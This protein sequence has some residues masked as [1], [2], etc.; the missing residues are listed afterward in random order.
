MPVT[1]SPTTIATAHAAI[2]RSLQ[3]A[4]P[5]VVIRE[6]V[7]TQR[8]FGSPENWQEDMADAYLE[9]MQDVPEDL[10]L[11]A[12][13][14]VRMNCR[15]FPRPSEFRDPIRDEL[16]ARKVALAKLEMMAS[17]VSQEALTAIARREQDPARRAEVAD[18]AVATVR[19]S[20]RT[21][22]MSAP[23]RADDV[24]ARAYAESLKRAAAGLAS[25]RLAEIGEA[26]AENMLRNWPAGSGKGG[27]K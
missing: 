5:M 9:A 4:D 18:R 8:I 20:A 1:V 16:S 17:R 3:P 10:T 11:K 21:V 24:P 27:G 12:C 14:H 22:M 7:K 25:F 2:A 19:A 15:F 26:E 6:L 23:P 13:R